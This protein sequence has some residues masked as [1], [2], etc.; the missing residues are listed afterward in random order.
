MTL[1]T[2][3]AMRQSVAQAAGGSLKDLGKLLDA[4]LNRDHEYPV[5]ITAAVTLTPDKHAGRLLVFDNAAG[6]TVTLPAASGSG[7]KY[8]FFVKT[9]VTS[10]SAKIQVANASDVMA[11]A[12]L[13]A[14]D[15]GDTIVAFEAAST[16]D[17]ITMNGTTTGGIKGDFFELEDAAEN[18]W[19]VNGVMSG[20]GT[21]ATPFS[22]AV[23]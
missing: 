3:L 15:S 16:S 18:L 5:S 7:H 21:E 19:R 8:R 17:T 9:T 2:T 13:V 22:A 14:Q 10:N 4:W 12:A 20:T 23:S 11:G 1:R 6:A